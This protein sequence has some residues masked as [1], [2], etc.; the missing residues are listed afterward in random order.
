M[1]G[2]FWTISILK[3]HFTSTL[4]WVMTR[5]CSVRFL[6]VMNNVLLYLLGAVI[7]SHCFGIYNISHYEK[8]TSN[9]CRTQEKGTE[10]EAAKKTKTQGLYP[11]LL[12]EMNRI[13]RFDVSYLFSFLGYSSFLLIPIWY[14][15]I[16][17]IQWVIFM[18]LQKIRKIIS[19][20]LQKTWKII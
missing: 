7:I 5:N 2:L 18:H 6:S 15:C 13:R 12:K 16:V 9:T 4:S 17:I 1:T 8:K 10:G 19:V 20:H 3:S 14:R 11:T